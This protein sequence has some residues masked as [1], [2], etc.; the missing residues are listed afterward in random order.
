MKDAIMTSYSNLVQLALRRAAGC[1]MAAQ[2]L[3]AAGA[4]PQ[5]RRRRGLRAMGLALP[6]FAAAL[7]T[8]PAQAQKPNNITEGEMAFLPVYCAD[9]QGF[10]Y[11]DAYFNT[12]PRAGH[13]I[14]L[15]GSKSF[16]AIHHYCWALIKLR[17]ANLPGVEPVMRK[18][19][20]RDAIADIDY[21][22]INGTPDFV[23]RPELL[24]LRGDIELMLNNVGDALTSYEAANQAKPDYWPPYV[25]WS[26]FL[27][28]NGLKPQARAFLE[29]GLRVTPD[30]PRLR[31]IYQRAG[32]DPEG[33]VRTLPPPAPAGTA[34]AATPTTAPSAT[35]AA[36]PASAAASAPN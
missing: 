26:E 24:T 16:W 29:R 13:W 11:G 23:L 32:G 27:L 35:P 17:R 21:V 1:E 25:N 19:G 7:L 4:D 22:L 3:P 28:K 5:R 30:E 2:S 6:L 20:M 9:A 8:T 14:G 10:K 18:G 33:F 36:P 34:S 31:T 12:S 15:M